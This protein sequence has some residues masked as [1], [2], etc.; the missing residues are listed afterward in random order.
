MV[1]GGQEI[2]PRAASV[3]S[4]DEFREPKRAKTEITSATISD[5]RDQSVFDSRALDAMLRDS[6]SSRLKT[7]AK[8]PWET[9][10]MAQVF[11]KVFNH[12]G[13]NRRTIPHHLDCHYFQ[14]PP[15]LS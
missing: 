1:C 7:C 15:L 2:Q 13:L 14:Y 4:S 9:G 6:L 11:N 8:F 5:N 3:A 12:A 10:Y